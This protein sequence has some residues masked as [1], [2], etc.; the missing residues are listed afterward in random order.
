MPDVVN[1]LLQTVDQ[2]NGGNNNTWGDIVDA[3]FLKIETAIAGQNTNT[4]SSGTVGLTLD[5]QR[6]MFQFFS[7]ALSGDLII[8]VAA[9]S[10]AWIIWNQTSGSFKLTLRVTGGAGAAYVVP[11][12]MPHLVFCDGANVYGATGSR[13]RFMTGLTLAAGGG[14]N[15]FT[16]AAGDCTAG[17]T[18][19]SPLSLASALIKT[20]SAWAAG[21][22]NGS[23]DTGAVSNNTWYYP[24]LIGKLDGTTDVITSLSSTAPLLPAGYVNYRR[25]GALKTDG[26]GNWV[27]FKQV[28]NEFLWD[29]SVQDRNNVALGS[30]SQLWTL[31][32]PPTA[33]VRA[34][35]RATATNAAANSAIL[36]TA[37]DESDQASAASSGRV[38]LYV[39]TPARAAA[40]FSTQAV[41]GQIRAVSNAGSTIVDLATFGWTD[42][43]LRAGG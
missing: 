1:A 33:G 31:S 3:N 16:V 26:S 23:L 34:R 19:Y 11:R 14:S 2:T 40:E 9:T 43:L 32:V 13:S 30:V 4:S 28:G 21:T 20:A 37:P 25:L 35:Y 39:N 7:G 12:G 6:P 15:Q 24:Y 27:K 42:T 36:F 29:V 10:K 17:A 22:G 38:S 18:P 5:Q 41:N 8:E